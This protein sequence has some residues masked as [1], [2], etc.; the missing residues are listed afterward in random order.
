[1]ANIPPEKIVEDDYKGVAF[2]PFV[3]YVTVANIC[4]FLNWAGVKTYYTQSPKLRDLVSHPKDPAH[5]ACT[6]Y[7]V[8]VVSNIL[9]KLKYL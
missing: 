5:H 3:K 8:L 2:M 6:V 9:V 7:L 1:M 4:R